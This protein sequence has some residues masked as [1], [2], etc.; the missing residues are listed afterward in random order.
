MLYRLSATATKIM[1][2]SL[3]VG[4]LL[5]TVDITA[6]QV[7]VDLGITPERVLSL[8][9]R[10]VTWAVPH[11]ILGSIVIVPVW[12]IIYLFRPPRG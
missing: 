1:L 5:S 9:Q 2:A 10:G 6:E 12:V 3:V 4:V 11:L 8:L 7:L